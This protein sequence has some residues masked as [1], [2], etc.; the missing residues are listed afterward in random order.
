MDANGQGAEP[1]GRLLS[2]EANAADILAYLFERDP[3]PL[4]AAFGLVH[5]QAPGFLREAR[6]GRRSRVD[7][8]VTDAGVPVALMELKVGAAEH[9]DQFSRY[10]D[11]AAAHGGISRHLVSLDRFTAHV[12][13]GWKQHLLTDL[14]QGWQ[15]SK[16]PTTQA[17]AGEAERALVGIVA[18]AAGP[19]G[20]AGRAALAVAMR[21]IAHLV[22]AAGTGAH[23]SSGA[24]RTSGG[25]PM[26]VFWLPHPRASGAHEWLCVDLRSEAAATTGW[27]LRLG[28]DVETASS[29]ERPEVRAH[30]LAMSLSPALAT[31]AFAAALRQANKPRLAAAL[32]GGKHDGFR[33]RFNPAVATAWR[34]QAVSGPAVSTASPLFAH[35][36]KRRLTTVSHL[37]QSALTVPEVANL[38]VTALRYLVA[39]A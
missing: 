32:S 31:S 16:D 23:P 20:Q 2:Q 6:R 13:A 35:D 1:L 10:D 21:H 27:K 19:L 14:L 8:F 37:D 3:E 30:D 9:G 28:V 38:V 12:P 25:Q 33:A 4:L 39:A 34:R 26:V 11:I 29:I 7:A 18:Q 5:L 36:R 15:N 24:D 17:V 22:H